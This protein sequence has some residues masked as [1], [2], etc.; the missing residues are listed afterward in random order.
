MYLEFY[1]LNEKPFAL[2]PN[3]AFLYPSKKHRLALTTLQYG[4]L[5]QEGFVVISGD[6][7]T[8]KTTLIHQILG[9]LD[10]RRFT[11]GLITNAH[12]DFSDLLQWVMMAFGQETPTGT[13]AEQYRS[14]LDFVAAEFRHMRR[15]V[16]IIDEAQNLSPA[17][18]EEL[19]MLVNVNSGKAAALQIVLVGQKQLLEK[20]R[21]PE[22]EQF[23]QRIAVNYRLEHLDPDDT[24]AYI[25]YRLALAG[26]ADPELFSDA[27][28][29]LVHRH[30]GGIPRIINLICDTSLVYGFADEQ[31]H[32]GEELVEAVV[33]DRSASGLPFRLSESSEAG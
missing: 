29:A 21:R 30:S 6:I 8:G 26:N 9:Q 27:A 7:G 13:K 18:L 4:L 5:G 20:L 33:N 14:F 1:R 15:T 28:C 3:P 31:F 25:R 19:R 2:T 32:I 22:L 10:R 16:L 24:A 23:A 17:T 12:E 11:C